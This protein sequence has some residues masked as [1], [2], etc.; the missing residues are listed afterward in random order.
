MERIGRRKQTDQF[1]VESFQRRVYDKYKSVEDPN[2]IFVDTSGS[3]EE[4]ADRIY[5]HCTLSV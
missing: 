1:E 2:V 3:K 5:N 4:T